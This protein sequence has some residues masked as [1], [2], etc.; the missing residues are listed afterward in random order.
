MPNYVD[1]IDIIDANQQTTNVLLQDR[2]TLAIANANT[3]K[4][5]SLSDLDTT[6]KSNLVG[7]INEVLLSG[8]HVT[9]EQFGAVGDG[10]TDDTRAFQDAI[11]YAVANKCSVVATQS[12][13]V[14]GLTV[15]STIYEG[16]TI[17]FNR[18]I[19]DSLSPLLTIEGQSINV[20]G[21][22]IVNDGGDGLQCGG[23]DY[24]LAGGTVTINLIKST[25]ANCITLK[26]HADMNIQD[27]VFNVTRLLYK[28]HAVKMDTTNRYVGE[29]TFN[30][31]WFNSLDMADNSYAIW[32]DCANYG[33][34][35][36][37]LNSCSFEG[38]G[39]GIQVL[40]T[41]PSGVQHQFMPLNGF[42]L[43][44]SELT[45]MYGKT[46]IDYHGNGR[47]IGD[48]TVDSLPLDK[49]VFH[50]S[51]SSVVG[52]SKFTINGR[53]RLKVGSSIFSRQAILTEDGMAFAIVDDCLLSYNTAPTTYTDSLP[54]SAHIRNQS[55][56][57]FAFTSIRFTGEIWILCD[58]TANTVTV[59]GTTFTPSAAYEVIKIKCVYLVGVGY[60]Y[61][62]E[63]NGTVTIKNP[64]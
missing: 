48:L 3:N 42:G 49:V 19:G 32:C 63:Q 9:P 22:M 35:G 15:S 21:N 64:V 10:V 28:I 2:G 11:D 13:K 14:S 31:T 43:R 53:I 46:F 61:L 55:T 56:L 29:I 18:I 1:N 60:R 40:N 5:G 16:I 8:L 30:G 57:T 58:A 25:V 6:E 4:I 59:N 24:G 47:L 45:E 12:Y 50:D 37:Y 44:V 41:S 33:M 38:A 7:A 36:L 62:V 54:Y 51:L 39:G 34:T 52:A 23:D 27:D 17:I 20:I 26:P